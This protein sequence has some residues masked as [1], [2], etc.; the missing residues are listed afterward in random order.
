MNIMAV[1]GLA[2]FGFMLLMGGVFWY[3]NRSKGSGKKYP[4]L[5]YNRDGS[6]AKKIDAKIVIDKE[7][8]NRKVFVFESYDTKLQIT[9]PT[10]YLDNV[11][12]RQVTP[13]NR[14]E[15]VYLKKNKITDEGYYE[16]NM[17]SEDV[18]VLSSMIVENSKEFENPMQKT[19]AALVIGMA[20]IALLIMIGN[21]YAV[22]SLVSNSGEM[23][24]IAQENS[25]TISGLKSA[26]ETNARVAE[27]NAKIASALTG[28][29]NL[30]RRIE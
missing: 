27:T 30:T 24:S 6:L 12:Y 20:V 7:Q 10:F 22:V 11:G 26:A 28:D 4:F 8:K 14:G 19:T 3:F 1:V 2:L 13:G 16:T 5:L 23:L 15:L 25:K 29:L 17:E 18:A 21:V 9:P